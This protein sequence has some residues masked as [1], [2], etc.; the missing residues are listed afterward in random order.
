MGT[1]DVYQVTSTVAT[2]LFFFNVSFFRTTQIRRITQ[3][4]F[5]ESSNQSKPNFRKMKLFMINIAGI[6][7]ILLTP[8]VRAGSKSN[9]CDGINNRK[10]YSSCGKM[11]ACTCLCR[12]CNATR[13]YCDLYYASLCGGPTLSSSEYGTRKHELHGLYRQNDQLT[14]RFLL[15]RLWKEMDLQ[16]RIAAVVSVFKSSQKKN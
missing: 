13:P 12:L 7:F 10:K 4:G 6:F 8:S 3:I 11:R 5:Q 16:R 14:E 15:H 1:T 2:K 9:P